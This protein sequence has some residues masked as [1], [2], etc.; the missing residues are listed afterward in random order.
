M[1]GHALIGERRFLLGKQFGVAR[2]WTSGCCKARPGAECTGAIAADR[3]V[4]LQADIL[5]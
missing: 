1:V 5:D 4:A 3:A 2:R